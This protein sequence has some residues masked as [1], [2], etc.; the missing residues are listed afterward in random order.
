[1]AYFYQAHS[2]FGY[3]DTRRDYLE[4]LLETDPPPPEAGALPPGVT[5]V[6][7]S[8]VMPDIE[9]WIAT[10]G[11]RLMFIYG[12]YDPWTA[13]M[14]ELG[15]ATDSF[16]FVDP[17]GTHGS[18]IRTLESEDRDAALAILQRWTGVTPVMPTPAKT[19]AERF[20]PWRMVPPD[21]EMP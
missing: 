18:H 1:M 19:A 21:V 12:E 14:V 8:E 4:D 13:G 16:I 11:D 3:P 7:D 17:G 9:Q 2:E 5:T 6:F 10:E 15:D 20:P